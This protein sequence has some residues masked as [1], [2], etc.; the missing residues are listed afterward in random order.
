MI[1][2]SCLRGG[3][4]VVVVVVEVVVEVD[5][6]AAVAAVAAAAKM[7][8]GSRCFLN[9]RGGWGVKVGFVAGL[10]RRWGR[11]L[12]SLVRVSALVMYDLC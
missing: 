3:V 9:E 10:Q 11:S 8:E 4:V 6:V 2:H 12:K 1:S 7:E 5:I